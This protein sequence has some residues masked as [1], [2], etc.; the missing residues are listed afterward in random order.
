MSEHKPWYRSA[1]MI[2]ATAAV[3]ASVAAVLVAVY[4]AWLDRSF[5][6]AATWPY[7]E[8]FRSYNDTAMSYTVTNQGTGPAIIRYAILEQDG[9]RYASWQQWLEGEYTLPEQGFVQSHISSRVLTPEQGVQ[10][11]TTPDPDVAPAIRANDQVNLTLC[12]CSVFEDCWLTDRDNEP[13]PTAHCD[14]PRG[15]T[16]QQ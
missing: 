16:F 12:Y 5:A 13:K 11:F 7:I 1:E 9:T 14:I 6:R 2:M 15:V 10:I 3:V 4:T 8:I